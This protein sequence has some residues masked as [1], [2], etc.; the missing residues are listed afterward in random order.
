MGSLGRHAFV[1][2]WRGHIA[3]HVPPV[4]IAGARPTATRSDIILQVHADIEGER[5]LERTAV[6]RKWLM[7]L[8]RVPTQPR[9]EGC[10]SEHGSKRLVPDCSLEKLWAGTATLDATGNVLQACAGTSHQL[11]PRPP[12]HSVSQKTSAAQ[13]LLS[14]HA[15][16]SPQP[17]RCCPGQSTTCALSMYQ[18][19]LVS[20]AASGSS[21]LLGRRCGELH[22]AQ[23]SRTRKQATGGSRLMCRCRPGQYTAHLLSTVPGA[24]L[25]RQWPAPGWGTGAVR[26][27]WLGSGS[28]GGS[29]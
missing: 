2:Q 25:R 24:S 18:G 3:A 19:G 14:Q 1:E 7:A 16:A 28:S 17:C 12:H 4:C 8:C 29:L 22:L 23:D 9:D 11:T 20:S 13:E 21:M 5:L 15:L 26:Y 6:L 10:W 27:S